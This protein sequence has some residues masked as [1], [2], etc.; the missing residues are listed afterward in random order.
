[1]RKEKKWGRE[2]MGSGLH[3]CN[4]LLK[5]ASPLSP[6]STKYESRSI[7]TK[8]TEAAFIHPHDYKGKASCVPPERHLSNKN[9]PELITPQSR[10]SPTVF[11]YIR[12]RMRNFQRMK[13]E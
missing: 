11:F 6:L 8:L 2:E 12:K 1:M 7:S 13:Y 5:I 9:E 10:D 4:L 3:S